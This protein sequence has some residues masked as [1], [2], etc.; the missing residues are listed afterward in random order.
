[1]SEDF[2]PLGASR[3][4][5][6]LGGRLL[7]I[8]S[9][10][11]ALSTGLA[12]G[13][14]DRVL[15]ADL[16]SAALGRADRAAE[17]V[18][19]LVDSHL[20]A[21]DERYRAI[22]RTPALRATLELG[23]A[24]TLLFYAEGLR[25]REGASAI[26][27]VGRDGNVS[28]RVG[29]SALI[30]LLSGLEEPDLI[31]VHGQ[32]HAVVSIPLETAG[33]S[34]GRLVAAEPL[35][36]EA[37]ETWSELS[38]ADVVVRLEPARAVDDAV[39]RLARE[40]TEFE[41]IVAVSMRDEQRAL[42]NS[43]RNLLAAGGVALAIAFGLSLLL[44]RSVTRPIHEIMTVTRRIGAGEFETRIST[45]RRD[46][47]GDVARAVDEMGERL[48]EY[49]GQVEQ[50]TGE[51][52]RS[53]DDV[54]RSRS[55]LANAQRL[56]R[57]GS[58]VLD[59]ETGAIEGSDEFR[60]LLGLTS[61]R[62]PIQLAAFLERVHDDDRLEV[63]R[64]IDS[65]IDGAAALRIDCRLV[66]EGH[67]EHVMHI[68]ARPVAEGPGRGLEGTMQDVTE[69]HR[70][71]EQI[72]FLNHHDPLTGLGNRRLLQE[73]LQIHLDQARRAGSRVGLVSVDLDRF[74]RINDS[75]G[76][77]AGDGLLKEVADR[78][79]AGVGT[80]EGARATSAISRLG[81]DEFT[82]VLHEREPGTGFANLARRL[83]DDLARPF[84]VDGHEVVV[85]ASAGLSVFPD[86]GDSAEELIQNAT[87]A[88][89][90]AKDEGGQRYQFYAGSMNEEAL[91]R[92]MMENELRRALEREEF[93]VH[94]QP[95]VCLL[96]SKLT[97]VE[98]LV[99]W[100]NQ[101]GQ[102]IS[103]G[104][105][106]PIAEETGLIMQLGEWVLRTACRQIAAW[107]GERLDLAVSVNLSIHQFKQTE[108]AELVR[109][110]L[111]ETGAPAELLE[112]EITESTLMDDMRGVVEELERLRALGIRIS[113]DDFGT[114]YSSFAYLRRLPVDTI[115]I[116]RSFV[117][118]IVESEADAQLAASIVQMGHALGLEVVA[119]G[120][121]TAE[122]RD[123]LVRFGCDVMQG[124][125]ISP[126]VEADACREI[127]RQR[128]WQRHAQSA[129]S[130]HSSSE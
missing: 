63:G 11:A 110:V 31:D 105:F 27:F 81:A 55:Q 118:E 71:Q 76:P 100:R 41:L 97:G 9:G 77:S 16:R 90:H 40:L 80:I 66:L 122:Q 123:L 18:G 44:A 42:A 119:E 58:W 29:E 12:L 93:E 72:Q 120:V 124:F 79:V 103:P 33:V 84:I 111:R 35:G 38:G 1:M 104:L 25:E 36:P 125:L 45:R 5:L 69:R 101:E 96:T 2:Q 67:G 107:H 78:L 85:G 10:I 6:G 49:R 128:G 115:K 22:S 83:I 113:L 117:S 21:L 24:P 26:A 56:A 102:L 23:D 53:I 64:A 92:L 70:A 28:A 43:R 130:D 57:M 91:R 95:K 46:E 98:A 129:W 47:I 126:A 34:V 3:L 30:E 99:R 8:L 82:I 20:D 116:D 17:A 52:E 106:I 65:C 37:F 121:E 4:R 62:K 86:D 48:D 51:L 50:Q 13:V 32:V 74:K 127:V 7:L 87:A 109:E 114:G 94:Y 19:T 59:E 108:L 89:R 54:E 14:Q 75:F 88:L 60:S 15:S 61:D 39:V 68:Q 112:L 73:R